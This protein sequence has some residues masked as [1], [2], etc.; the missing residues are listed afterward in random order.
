MKP[1][2]PSRPADG[3]AVCDTAGADGSAPT[4]APGTWRSDLIQLTKARLTTLVLVT[5]G[6]GFLLASPDGVDWPTLIGTLIG[7]ALVAAGSSVFNQ[8]IERREDARMERTRDRPIPAGRMTPSAAAM[9]ATLASAAG[10]VLLAM[11]TTRTATVI[12]ALTWLVY[13]AVY[14]P[15]KIRSPACTLVGAVSGALP[16]V[17]GWTAAGGPLDSEAVY[18]FALLFLWQL[19][20]FLAIN[21]MYRH[22][23]SRA[24]FRMWSNRDESG[25]RTAW[26]AVLFSTALLAATL[27]MPAPMRS[28]SALAATAVLAL[29]LLALAV[30]FLRRP[31][32]ESARHLF[33][34]TLLYL[35]LQL[36]VLLTLKGSN[37]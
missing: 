21:W 33:L 11:T 23:Y 20:H 7:T 4:A 29:A 31:S 15:M 35:P 27:A 3:T 19:P 24:G 2:S 1:L 16:P 26:L 17:I 36:L 37:P 18:L 9:G 25:R 34:G 22:E 12:A 8:I 13:V 14:T 10:I 30:R 5:S 32:R 6:V 28:P